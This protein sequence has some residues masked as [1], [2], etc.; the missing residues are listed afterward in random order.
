MN[1]LGFFV[2]SAVIFPRN[3]KKPEIFKD[4]SEG[5]VPMTSGGGFINSKLFL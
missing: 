1:P 4:V 3:R 2:P 5:T